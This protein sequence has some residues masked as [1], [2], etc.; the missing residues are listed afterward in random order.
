MLMTKLSVIFIEFRKRSIMCGLKTGN[1]L[2]ELK[3]FFVFSDIRIEKIQECF[4]FPLKTFS[5][6][7]CLRE[8]MA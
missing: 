5:T 1:F 2:M 8:E 7:S 6:I 4:W 3:F